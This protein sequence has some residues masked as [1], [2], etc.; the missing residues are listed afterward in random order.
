MQCA[1][2]DAKER[3]GEEGSA[4]DLLE[5]EGVQRGKC[6]KEKVLRERRTAGES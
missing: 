4:H 6:M 2:S 5:E 3:E 1:V